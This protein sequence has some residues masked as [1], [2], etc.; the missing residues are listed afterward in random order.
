MKFKIERLI[1]SVNG[2]LVTSIWQA[3][4]Y[5]TRISVSGDISMQ[6]L[7]TASNDISNL[8]L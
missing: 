4:G 2:T 7:H 5:D 8:L 1:L 3:R 6:T